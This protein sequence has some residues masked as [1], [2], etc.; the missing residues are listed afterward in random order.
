[1]KYLPLFIFLFSCVQPG[2]KINI[3]SNT[4]VVKS[5]FDAYN[6]HDWATVAGCYA[7]S[8]LVMDPALGDSAVYQTQQATIKRLQA[9]QQKYP[10]LKAQIKE[11]Y[12][13]RGH[14]IVE[15]TAEGTSHN[16]TLWHLPQCAVFTLKEGKISGSNTYYDKR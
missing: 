4:Q 11:I 16:N 3:V 7:D 5:L 10:D 14:V 1:M 13:D 8:T 9:L 15:F 12:S 6:N 2:G